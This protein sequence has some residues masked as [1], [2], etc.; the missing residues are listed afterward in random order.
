MKRYAWYGMLLGFSSIGGWFI[1]AGLREHFVLSQAV[2]L[3]IL[4]MGMLAVSFHFLGHAIRLRKFFPILGAGIAAGAIVTIVGLIHGFA[5]KTHVSH[6]DGDLAKIVETGTLAEVKSERL[7]AALAE[8]KILQEEIDATLAQ[9]ATAETALKRLNEVKG[10]IDRL[11]AEEKRWGS[12]SSA[13]SRELREAQSEYAASADKVAKVSAL[14]AVLA[15]KQ[16]RSTRSQERLDLMTA[17]EESADIQS[18]ETIGKQKF[19]FAL[20]SHHAGGD[21]LGTGLVIAKVGFLVG[22]CLELFVGILWALP[23]P[24]PVQQRRADIT[25][26]A[27]DDNTPTDD[28]D[29]DTRKKKQEEREM[30]ENLVEFFQP[31]EV[32]PPAQP[33]ASPFLSQLVEL[34]PRIADLTVT[35][36]RNGVTA[37][38]GLKILLQLQKNGLTK[39]RYPWKQH[40]KMRKNELDGNLF[41]ELKPYKGHQTLR[42]ILTEAL[43]SKMMARAGEKAAA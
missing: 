35:Q 25:D 15:S 39:D 19:G 27:G 33:P 16:E 1:F 37:K 42:E 38:D 7:R 34:D 12:L 10:E 21:E 23:Y 5:L 31:R 14:R 6:E 9:I 32:A 36:V 28:D 41:K 40:R 2:P 29:P 8:H 4:F 43:A 24:A 26:P 22:W 17:A 11:T 13:K 30:S 20:A 3:T 18:R